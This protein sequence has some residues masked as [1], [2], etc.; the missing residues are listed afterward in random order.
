MQL[1]LVFG[2]C[3]M[4]DTRTRVTVLSI[5][6]QHTLLCHTETDRQTLKDASPAVL[7]QNTLHNPAPFSAVFVT[8][9]LRQ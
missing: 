7:Y 3:E 1:H 9:H 8:P 5:C 4:S 2:C 6:V